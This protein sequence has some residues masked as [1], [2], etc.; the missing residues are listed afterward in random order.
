[1]K[2]KRKG[3]RNSRDCFSMRTSRDGHRLPT[4]VAALN[5]IWRHV[6]YLVGAYKRVLAIQI[7]SGRL[8]L[9]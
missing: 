6:R 1:L 9:V 5:L 3:I 2:D 8:W 4:S 7:T